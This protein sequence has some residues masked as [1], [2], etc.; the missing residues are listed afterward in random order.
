MIARHSTADPIQVAELVTDV[1]PGP[2][3]TLYTRIGDVLPWVSMA[4]TVL[5]G[6]MAL[7]RRKRAAQ[8]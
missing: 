2:G 6:L 3:A 8:T 1:A 7:A 4:A 5:L